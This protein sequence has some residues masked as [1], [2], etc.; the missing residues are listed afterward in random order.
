M[1]GTLAMLAILLVIVGLL[2]LLRSYS[3]PT[4]LPPY[5]AEGFAVA[6]VNS[7]LAP[8]CTERSTQAQSLLH[9]IAT[10]DENKSLGNEGNKE[11]LRLL[12]SKLCCLEADLIT[13]AAGAYRTL[14]L[15]FRTSHDTDAASTL[16]GRCF[17][18]A[19]RQRDIDIIV[20]KFQVRGLE[21]VG[22]LVNPSDVTEA[23]E[24]FMTV[25]NRVKSALQSTCLT[26]Q[27]Q[28][29]TPEG[30]RDVGFWEPKTA[31]GLAQYQGISAVPK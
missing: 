21:L 26:Y 3:A 11:E 1:Y 20:E 16:V 15:Q 13:P 30:P 2:I 24:E 9:R 14:P 27:P 10:A 8:A 29:D 22:N 7:I 12:L 4:F 25:I 19:L 17:R 31:A 18:N 28:L 23:K 6:A 5:S